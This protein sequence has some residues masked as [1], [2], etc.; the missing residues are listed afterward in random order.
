MGKI[1]NLKEI[2]DEELDKY[3]WVLIISANEP[4]FY[5]F[6]REFFKP[7]YCLASGAVHTRVKIMKCQIGGC[8]E[9]SLAVPGDKSYNVVSSGEA[10]KCILAISK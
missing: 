10:I 7:P 8:L 5:H 4:L 6:S 3:R 2:S 1:E 9:I